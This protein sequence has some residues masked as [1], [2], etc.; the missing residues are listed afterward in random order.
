MF[1]LTMQTCSSELNI[2]FKGALALFV[3]VFLAAC[4]R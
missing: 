4:A 3:L 1:T 2:R